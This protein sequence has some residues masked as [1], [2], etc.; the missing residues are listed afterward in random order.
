MTWEKKKR[1]Q[2]SRLRHWQQGALGM[3]IITPH[4]A[5]VPTATRGTWV[6]VP[7][8]CRPD[9]QDENA[10]TGH[11]SADIGVGASPEM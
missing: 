10:R 4:S 7:T 8:N 2:W 1:A 11:A 9:A 6:R 3:Y 5:T